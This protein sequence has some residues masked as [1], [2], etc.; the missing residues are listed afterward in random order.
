MLREIGIEP[1]YRCTFLTATNTPVERGVGYAIL[2]AESFEAND[3]V[4]FAEPGDM[5][6]LGVRTMEGFGVS[7]DP[8]AHRFSSRPMIVAPQRKN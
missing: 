1:R 4:V 6:L 8:I 5:P 7:V 3:H 2:R